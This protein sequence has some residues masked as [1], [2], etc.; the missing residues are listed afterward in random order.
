MRRKQPRH[1]I[2]PRTEPYA[3][4]GSPNR[5]LRS[6]VRH[7]AASVRA[8]ESGY[9]LVATPIAVAVRLQKAVG[10]G[11]CDNRLFTVGVPRDHIIDLAKEAIGVI[12]GNVDSAGEVWTSLPEETT[13]GY[14][15]GAQRLAVYE[16]HPIGRSGPDAPRGSRCERVHANARKRRDQDRDVVGSEP[17]DAPGTRADPDALVDP[18]RESHHR[19]RES[20]RR[21]HLTGPRRH[22]N[23]QYSGDHAPL[24]GQ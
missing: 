14:V 22:V 6:P 1:T 18:L 5:T 23:A 20:A 19:I 24:R 9:Q 4:V 7:Q 15:P 12:P 13:G 17:I 2:V 8:N 21:Q 10:V 11:D 3:T 16:T